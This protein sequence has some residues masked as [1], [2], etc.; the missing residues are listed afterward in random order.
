MGEIS[1]LLKDL[2]K[3]V[4]DKEEKRNSAQMNTIKENKETQKIEN[5][6]VDVP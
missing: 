6:L 4:D 2:K 1:S 5:N 3:Y